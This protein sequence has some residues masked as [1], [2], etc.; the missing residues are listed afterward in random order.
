MK[1]NEMKDKKE[2]EE[3]P[4]IEIATTI[5]TN[6]GGNEKIDITKYSKEH[7]ESFVNVGFSTKCLHV[8]QEPDYIYGA[9]NPS[10]Q[11]STTFAQKEPGEPFGPYDYT[12]AGN[13]TRSNLERLIAGLESAKFAL[14]W[15]SG[16]SAV[17]GV[18]HLLKTGDE[19]IC[20]DDVYGGTQR[21]FKKI[22]SI[23]QGVKFTFVSFEN[24]ELLKSSLNEKTKIVISETSTNPTLK[25]T[26]LE[27]LIQT[28]K[29]YNPNILVVID[30]TFMSPYNCRPLELGADVV[31]ESA[32]K[33][34][35]GHS[36]ILM[37]ITATNDKDIHD[38]L[39]FIHKSMGSV[40]SP[41]DCYMAI[42]GLKTLSIRMER[43]NS[44]ALEIAK[45]LENHPL[46]EKVIYPG[47]ES[48]YY[49]KLAKKQF[50]GFGGMVSFVIKGGLKEAKKFLTSLKVFILAES[51]GGVESLANHPGLMTH[52]SLSEEI[53]LQLGITDGFIRLSVGVEDIEDLIQDLD[54]AL[55]ST[56]K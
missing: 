42:R 51:L 29:N 18:I 21:Y 50:R 11:L 35:G 17:S 31:I 7:D 34:F 16:M 6:K 13:P 27:A 45:F 40:S 25:V 41:F 44:N 3:F 46:V 24:M 49:H 14:A 54:N 2:K 4:L 23:S 1:T 48:N 47:L 38:R 52:A 33:Y 8:G 37:G 20:V 53:R 36:D 55:K 15:S 22:S 56:K 43:H 12:R 32:T 9:L 30:N 28:T 39:Y 5:G 10:I 26:D 19:V